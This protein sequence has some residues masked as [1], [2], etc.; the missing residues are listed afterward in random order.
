MRRDNKNEK[1]L[2]VAAH[3]ISKEG[4]T[5]VSLQEIANKVGLHKSSLFHYIKNKEELL[6]LIFNKSYEEVN[7]TLK[8]INVDISLE[9]EEKLKKAIDSHLTLLIEHFDSTNIFL[10]QIKRLPKKN[11]SIFLKERKEYEKN[12]QKII[13]EMKRKGY[14]EGLDKQIVTLGLL[15]MLNWVPVWFRRDGRLTIKEISN[16]FYRLIVEKL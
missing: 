8:E 15:G 14:F 2:S 6:L 12:F 16:I 5:G 9:P 3:L 11:Q 10:H 1:I 7:R 4:Y 13:V